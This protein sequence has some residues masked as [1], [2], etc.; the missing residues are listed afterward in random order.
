MDSGINKKLADLYTFL[1]KAGF[2]SESQFLKKALGPHTITQDEEGNVHFHDST[3]PETNDSS[4]TLPH[5]DIRS[6]LSKDEVK[7]IQKLLVISGFP[8]P[9]HGVDGLLG[10][11]T[12]NA[13]KDFKS[14]LKRNDG[15]AGAIDDKIDEYIIVRLEEY[16][17][18]KD[19]EA[20]IHEQSASTK[21][22]GADNL[23]RSFNPVL[24][25]GDSQ[26]VGALGSALVGAAGGGKK[27]AKTG[28]RA[29]YW[30]SNRS[31]KREL[32]KS[33]DKIIISLN[34]N[35]IGGT[36][37]LISLIKRLSPDSKVIWTG[38]PPPIKKKRSSKT[39]ARY[40]T[41]DWGFLAAYNKRNERNKKVQAMV[42]AEGWTFINPYD[43]I[44]YDKPITVAGKTIQSGYQCNGC[45]G[46]H[47]PSH[48]ANAY[49]NKIQALV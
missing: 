3:E 26:M 15:Y 42:E 30:A 28:T 36:A 10:N 11:E 8:L 4:L 14:E 49:V 27:L 39:W 35:G 5:D 6:D 20:N 9:K 23:Q 45:D 25:I 29:S 46:I 12:F 2:L 1:A 43:Y 16:A 40:L 21:A 31:L 32:K 17:A 34:G 41:T 37:R 33:P 13:I 22:V 19:P 47:L 24:Y 18:N 48:A 7:R 44:K 38:A